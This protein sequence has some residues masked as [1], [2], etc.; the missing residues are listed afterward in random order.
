MLK[1][2]ARISTEAQ[3][4]IVLSMAQTQGIFSCPFDDLIHFLKD[5]LDELTLR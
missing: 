1:L 4:E 2:K 5:E 3:L